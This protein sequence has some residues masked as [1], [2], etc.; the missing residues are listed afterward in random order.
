[1]NRMGI[2]QAMLSVID[3]I[4]GPQGSSHLSLLQDTVSIT[5]YISLTF[6]PFSNIHL[7]YFYTKLRIRASTESLVKLSDFETQRFYY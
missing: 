5:N 6:R 7:M 4:Y 1:M 2:M 3:L